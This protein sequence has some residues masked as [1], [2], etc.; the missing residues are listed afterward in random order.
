MNEFI[1]REKASTITKKG[2]FVPSAPGSGTGRAMGG[3]LKG[4]GEVPPKEKRAA[5]NP[6]FETFLAEKKLEIPRHRAK[7]WLPVVP[8]T[9]V[10]AKPKKGFTLV[11]ILV[12]IGLLTVILAIAV[13][14]VQR[15][16][17]NLHLKSAARGV[18]SDIFELKQKALSENT[19]FSIIF[20]SVENS[21]TIPGKT[22]GEDQ[23]KTFTN[24][25]NDIRLVSALF[26]GGTTMA[27]QTGGTT[28]DGNINLTNSRGSTATVAINIAG[29]TYVQFNML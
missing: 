28:T 7:K 20:D 11:E 2:M 25:G 4:K 15:H 10:S 21:Y 27:I 29:R 16:V 19:P 6:A 13:P 22:P 8:V 9:M 26:N 18:E 14:Q 24:F 3:A 23:V 5:G 17:I 1:A 12:V